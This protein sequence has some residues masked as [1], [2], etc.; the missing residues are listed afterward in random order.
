M[1]L[2]HRHPGSEPGVLPLNYPAVVGSEGVEPFVGRPTCFVDCGFTDRRGEHRPVISGPGGTRTH[3]ISWSEQE[4]ST[5]IAY[6]ANKKSQESYDA[7]LA[8]NRSLTHQEST[9]QTIDDTRHVPAKLCTI[10]SGH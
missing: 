7:W 9:A 3:S 8:R 2:N 10:T 6:R 4:W 5:G 1:D